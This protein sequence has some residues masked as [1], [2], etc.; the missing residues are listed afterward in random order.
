MAAQIAPI[1]FHGLRHTYASRLVMR[2]VP[3]TVIATQLGHADIQMVEKHYAH[4]APN[5]VAHTVRAAFDN[6]GIVHRNNV[7]PLVG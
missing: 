6:M 1:P 7:L 2:N 5:Y 4:L 3:L